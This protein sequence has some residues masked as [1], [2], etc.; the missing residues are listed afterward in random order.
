MKFA[1]ILQRQISYGEMGVVE[2]DALTVGDAVIEAL[3]AAEIGSVYWGHRSDMA[4]FGRATVA[5]V[6][7]QKEG[8]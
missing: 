8:E 2:V 6:V 7:E 3:R 1:I 5:H 4:H